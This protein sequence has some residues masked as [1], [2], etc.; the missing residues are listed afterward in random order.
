LNFDLMIKYIRNKNFTRNVKCPADYRF[1][2]PGCP[3]I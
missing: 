2:R 3:S 1:V